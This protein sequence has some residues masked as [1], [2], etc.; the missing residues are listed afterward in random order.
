MPQADSPAP[1]TADGLQS[2]AATVETLPH[3][4]NRL[5][6]GSKSGG[7]TNIHPGS[8][9]MRAVAAV[10]TFIAGSAPALVADELDAVVM[11]SRRDAAARFLTAGRKFTP[12]FFR[13][14]AGQSG[15]GTGA[16][17]A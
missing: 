1:A 17:E 5:D 6:W 16:G 4:V 3:S 2:A 13:S 12:L 7:F 15:F 9:G 14:R 11:G 8:R 10:V